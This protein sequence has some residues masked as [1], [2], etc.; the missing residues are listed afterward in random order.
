[1]S[2]MVLMGDGAALPEHLKKYS[3]EAEKA[4]SLVTGFNAL[5]SLS[6]RGKRF[7]LGGGEED[8]VYP[9]G[10]AIDVVILETDPPKGCAKSFYTAAY[11][12]DADDMPDCFSSDGITPDEF[13]TDP[14]SRSCTECPNNAFGS[15]MK[16]GV[17]TK[18][19]A[20]GDHKNLF[21]VEASDLTGTVMALRVPATSLKAL[22]GYG[23]KLAKF[24]VAPQCVVS[25]L[26]FTDAA[27]HPQL[28]F[29]PKC[30]LDADDSEVSVARSHSDEVQFALP[31]KNKMTASEL[32]PAALE[33]PIETK[34]LPAPPK[35]ALQLTA[36]AGDFTLEQFEAQGWTQEQLIEQGYLE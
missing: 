11:S 8:V 34:A 3:A 24:G 12:T 20:C 18:G 30:Y 19:K 32:Q 16:E 5:P 33:G 21:V 29:N 7:R 23:R 36:L 25:T 28:E 31:S 14:V 35:K 1:M 4:A 27:D 10:Q 22:S 6:I 15:G 13:V 17:P 26:S 9:L 2:E